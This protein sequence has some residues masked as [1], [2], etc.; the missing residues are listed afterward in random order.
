[1]PASRRTLT[2]S[3]EKRWVSQA[4]TSSNRENSANILTEKKQRDLDALTPLDARNSL[5][6]DRPKQESDISM[7]PISAP[8]QEKPGRSVSPDR[9]IAAEE[10][11]PPSN[12]LSSSPP[13]YRNLTHMDHS[14]D[15]QNLISGAA[16]VGW[17]YRDPSPPGTGRYDGGY[18]PPRRQSY[19]YGNGGG[20]RV[21]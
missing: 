21:F 2:A 4:R 7:F 17:A 19:G 10:G 20:Y 3:E 1:M 16:P 11:L 5:L 18:S 12:Q 6:L 14:N 9:Y 13:D 8:L 15:T